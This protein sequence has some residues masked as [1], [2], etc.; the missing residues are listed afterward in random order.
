M[1]GSGPEAEDSLQEGGRGALGSPLEGAGVA[2][3]Q[4]EGA[5][6]ALEAPPT[7]GLEGKA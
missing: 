2:L 3:H 7:V 4:G 5:E 6:G 1:P